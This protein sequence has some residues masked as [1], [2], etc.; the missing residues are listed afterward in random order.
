MVDWSTHEWESRQQLMLGHEIAL[1][2]VHAVRLVGQLV[3][4]FGFNDM[5]KAEFKVLKL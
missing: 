5:S 3:G 4:T 1:I 2:S